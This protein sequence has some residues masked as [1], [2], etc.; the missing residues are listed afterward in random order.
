M[1]IY[2]IS[3]PISAELPAWP[4]DPQ[5]EIAPVARLERGDGANVS[6]VTLSTHS[7]THID[8]P[9]HYDDRG[10]PVDQLPLDL[11]VGEALVV[12]LRNVREIGRRE[13]ARYPI[14]GVE[15]VLLKTDNSL[16]WDR[17]GFCEE[18]AHLTEEGAGYLLEAGVRLVGIDYLSVERFGS[19]GE[20]HRLLLANGVII[21]EGVKL[22]GVAEGRYELLALPLKIRGGDGAPA[23]ALLCRRGEPAGSKERDLHTTR[24]PL[25]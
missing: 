10:I 17:A 11:L 23:R 12:D 19:G 24:W 21:L 6:R 7:G 4:G 8:V 20:I 18:Y 2:D 22:D 1:E 15:R 16:L 13:L 5:V 3:V 25:A 9:R 14:R